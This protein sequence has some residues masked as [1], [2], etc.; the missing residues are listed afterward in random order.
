MIRTFQMLRQV[1]PGFRDPAKVQTFQLTVPAAD[2][3][4]TTR[5]GGPG[6]EQTIRIKHAILD[7]L[8]AVAGVASAGFSAFND[9]LPLDGDGRTNA[10]FVEGKAPVAGVS[11]QK[12][13]QFVSP[14]FFETL[15]TPL[16]AG[17][18]FDWND[19]YQNRRVVLVSENVARTEWG[20]A[21]AAIGKRI[22]T[23]STGPWSEIVGVV[24]DVHHNGLNQ[25]APQVL[26][27]PAVASATASFV[28][29]SERVGTTGFLDELRKAV[30]LVNGNLSLTEVQ[31]LG[32]LYQR[33]TARTSMTLQLLAITGAMALLLGLIGIYGVVSYSVSQR[34]REIGI[35]LAL[36]ARRGEVRMMFVRHALVLVGIGVAIGLGAAVGVTRLMESQLFGVSPLDPLTH[37]A[38]ALVL[39]TAAGFASYLSAHRGSALNPVEVLKAQ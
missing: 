21:P 33:S 27:F 19:V 11:S 15:R 35:R 34:R 23:R 14:Q 31:T 24:K 7:R 37:L 3:P 32:D 36:G 28:I 26:A 13:L 2:A 29:R 12:E 38:V 22:A 20:S 16:I 6:P 5:A 1:D 30:W 10:M 9:G 18:T 25:P 4:D 8:T 39:T 17:R